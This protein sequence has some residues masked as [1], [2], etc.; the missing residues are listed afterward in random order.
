MLYPNTHKPHTLPLFPVCLCMIASDWLYSYDLSLHT[1]IFFLSTKYP[2]FRRS[3]PFFNV[4]IWVHY[5]PSLV[6]NTQNICKSIT[7][8][9]WSVLYARMYEMLDLLIRNGLVSSQS[10][11]LAFPRLSVPVRIYLLLK[12][13]RKK[14]L[15]NSTFWLT[16]L[17][18]F[19]KWK[20]FPRKFL[21]SIRSWQR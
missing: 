20:A 1:T 14:V 19:S 12:G 5:D 3:W 16:R 2:K 15:L 6:I 8:Q 10:F 13:Q 17:W 11:K 9:V 18:N 7:K 4:C 21:I